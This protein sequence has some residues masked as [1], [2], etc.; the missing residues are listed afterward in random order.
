[1]IGSGTGGMQELLEKSRQIII[2]DL[3]ALNDAIQDCLKNGSQNIDEG[4]QYAI[5][6]DLD[7]FKSSWNTLIEELV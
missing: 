4:Y 5:Q 1:M 2:K 7:Y 6:F 3:T